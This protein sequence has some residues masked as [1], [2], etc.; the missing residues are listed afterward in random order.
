MHGARVS[1]EPPPGDGR[2]GEDPLGSPQLLSELLAAMYPGSRPVAMHSWSLTFED[3]KLERKYI[4]ELQQD[5]KLRMQMGAAF[6]VIIT[7]V[8]IL[9]DVL[10]YDWHASFTRVRVATRIFQFVFLISVALYL[11]RQ[12]VDRDAETSLKLMTLYQ[13]LCAVG[14]FLYCM[15]LL[16]ISDAHLG[17][18]MGHTAEFDSHSMVLIIFGSC[19]GGI[20]ALLD[21]FFTYQTLIYV[22]VLGGYLV[23]V[24]IFN[25]LGYH[26]CALEMGTFTFSFGVTA[27]GAGLVLTQVLSHARSLRYHPLLASRAIPRSRIAFHFLTLS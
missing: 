7:V 24:F 26:Q 8:G 25:S 27:F 14:V 15:S 1:M 12:P 20:L 9:W 17:R 18:K 6:V 19:L 22:N 10:D 11:G 16:A 3:S 13:R 2:D 5:R 23:Q 4:E 21:I